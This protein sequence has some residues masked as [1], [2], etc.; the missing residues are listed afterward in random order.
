[1]RRLSQVYVASLLLIWSSKLGRLGRQSLGQPT[2]A[3]ERALKA[4]RTICAACRN[5]RQLVKMGMIPS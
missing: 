1:M 4:L 5:L 2:V 3:A